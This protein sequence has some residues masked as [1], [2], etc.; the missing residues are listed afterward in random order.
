MVAP[1]PADRRGPISESALLQQGRQLFESGRIG[2]AR[3]IFENILRTSPQNIRAAIGA[4]RCAAML[5][6]IEEGI[7]HAREAVALDGES[8]AAVLLLAD[9]LQQGLHGVESLVM[10][11]RALELNPSLTSARSIAAGTLEQMQEFDAALE[12]INA[13]LERQPSDPGLLVSAA[14]LDVRLKDY[15]GALVRLRPLAS[16]SDLRPALRASALNIMGKS[17]DRLENYDEAFQAFVEAGQVATQTHAFHSADTQAKFRQITAYRQGFTAETVGRFNADD[18]RNTHAA[19]GLLVGFPRSGTTLTEQILAAHPHIETS[20][21]RPFFGAV[22]AAMAKLSPTVKDVN[23]TIRRLNRTDATKLRQIYWRD[24]EEQ[25]GKGASEASTFIDK[26]PLNIIGLGIINVIFP[27]SRVLI[28]LRDPRDVCLSC[29]FQNFTLNNS[30]VQFTSLDG[31]ARFYEAVMGLYL[32][33][34]DTLTLEMLEVRYEDTVNDLEK[35]ARRFLAH[36]GADWSE[37]VLTFYEKARGRFI[38][39]PSA[40]AVTEKINSSAVERYKNYEKYLEPIL[41]I[42]EPFIDEFGY[43]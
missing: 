38:G 40:A 11:R 36:V 17:L 25:M 15:D 35:Q 5:G 41:P 2:Q 18:F 37:E 30:M 13:G 39:T 42:L 19:P 27:E 32:Y 20:G 34:R 28:A 21:E 14:N 31:T 3:Q 23:E 7:A 12:I 33:Y 10:A 22:G 4:G 24:V 8:E 1:S 43:G 26:L 6:R 29:F 16:R 9:L